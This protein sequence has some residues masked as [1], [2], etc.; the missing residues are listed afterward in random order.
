MTPNIVIE[1][2]KGDKLI[3]GKIDKLKSFYIP[4]IVLGELYVGI[5]RVVNKAK[6]LK[7]LH[8]FLELST[9]ISIDEETTKY[10][11]EI[12]AALYKKGKP[13]PINDAWIAASAKQHEFTLITRD[14]HFNEIKDIMGTSKNSISHAV[15]L[16]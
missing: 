9:V 10:Y 14:K 6:H 11:G 15:G 5:N 16:E 2:F 13:I 7:M 3:A 12:V 8:K 4:A 1:V